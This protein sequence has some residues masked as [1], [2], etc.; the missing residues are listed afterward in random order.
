MVLSFLISS[1]QS[2]YWSICNL[3][4]AAL[5]S[6]C[7]ALA[8]V[9]ILKIVPFVATSTG[10]SGAICNLFQH[11]AFRAAILLQKTL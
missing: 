2:V 6:S 11:E 10:V 7:V 1:Y 8:E 4:F 5:K 9:Y 3:L